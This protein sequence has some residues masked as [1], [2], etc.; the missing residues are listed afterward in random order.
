VGRE[1]EGIGTEHTTFMR[2]TDKAQNKARNYED[3]RGAE[4]PNC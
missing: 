1:G 2:Y 4:S 3:C